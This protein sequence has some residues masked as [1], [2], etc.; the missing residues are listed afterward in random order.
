MSQQAQ[1]EVKERPVLF[2]GPMVKAILEGKKTQTQAGL[3]TCR[4]ETWTL[5]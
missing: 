3:Q 1:A 4:Y 5:H 2:S